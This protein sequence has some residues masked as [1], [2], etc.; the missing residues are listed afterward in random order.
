MSTNWFYGLEKVSCLRI[1]RLLGFLPKLQGQRAACA[2]FELM[3][4]LAEEGGYAKKKAQDEVQAQG[5]CN[6]YAVRASAHGL[7]FLH[8]GP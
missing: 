4:M 3:D 7:A 6:Y 1:R 8:S 2:K 5:R